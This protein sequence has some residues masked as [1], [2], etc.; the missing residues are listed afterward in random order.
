VRFKALTRKGRR[1]TILGLTVALVVVVGGG[2]AWALKRSSSSSVATPTLVTATT[3]TIRQSVSASGTLQPA[4]RADLSFDVAG[5]VTSLPVAVG[6]KVKVGAILA[7][8]DAASLNTAVTLAQANVTA[9]QDQLTTQQDAGSSAVQIAWSQ[10]Q[11]AD[12]R[13]KLTDAKTALAG[14]SMT[15]PIAG[16]VADVNIA[17]GDK[18]GTA[19]SAGA[20]PSSNAGASS[21]S[22]SASTAQVVVISTTSWVVEANV[23]SADLPQLKKGLQ[24]EITPTGSTTKVFGTVKSVGIVA[25]SSSSSSSPSSS[26]GSATFPVTIV[27]TGSPKGLYAGGAATVAIIVRLVE[28]VLTVPTSALHTESGKNV[29]H[30]LRAGAQVS[31]PVTV[32][33]PYGAVT[34]IIAGLKVGDKV[35]GST[36][37]GGSLNG[38]TGTRQGGGGF[39]GGGFGGGGAGG[40]GGGVGGP[41]P[42]AGGGNR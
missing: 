31:T 28:N 6:E 5:T 11:L 41:P 9:T 25:S 21:A 33:T 34:Q 19:A 7:T 10:A 18:V 22:T 20:S 2:G 16:T 38:T 32:G 14:A 24:T 27:V 42:G 3:S 12:A 40:G 17:K 35:I 15:S 4:S 29:V 39:G 30:Q 26:S 23:G 37:R 1:L 13:S 8:V 36:F